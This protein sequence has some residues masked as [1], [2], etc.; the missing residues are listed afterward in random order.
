[1]AMPPQSENG[2][3]ERNSSASI[4]SGDAGDPQ[5]TDVNDNGRDQNI[6]TAVD[7]TTQQQMQAGQPAARE[8]GLNQQEAE[9]NDPRQAGGYIDRVAP[10]Q[11]FAS[12]GK[13]QRQHDREHQACPDQ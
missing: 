2:V 9:S 13:G 10:R 5:A 6:P 1:M 7:K 4:M 12:C 3:G 8:E 11:V